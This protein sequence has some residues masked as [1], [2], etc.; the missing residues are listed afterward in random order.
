MEKIKKKSLDKDQ[1]MWPRSRD[2]IVAKG[3]SIVARKWIIVAKGW[4]I[5]VAGSQ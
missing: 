5:V 2:S 3:W 4:S 1:I